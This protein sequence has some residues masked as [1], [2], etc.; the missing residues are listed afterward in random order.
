MI[1]EKKSSE[2]VYANNKD[3]EKI[4]VDKQFKTIENIKLVNGIM[5]DLTNSSLRDAITIL[6]KLGLKYKVKGSGR[7][8]SQSINAGE[9]IK[10]GAVC[11]IECKDITL[12]GTYVY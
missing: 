7:V 10:N 9:K 3:D 2:F 11:A 12:S 8:I 6:T 5:P 1:N 4:S